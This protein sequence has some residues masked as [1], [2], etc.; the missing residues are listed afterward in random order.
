[1][2]KTKTCASSCDCAQPPSAGWSTARRMIVEALLR[3][4]EDD[5]SNVL[6]IL[7]S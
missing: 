1:M 7:S 6:A 5:K 2:S 3:H 4:A